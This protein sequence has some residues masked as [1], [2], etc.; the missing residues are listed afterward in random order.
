MEVK[1]TELVS[2]AY[3]G[4]RRIYTCEDCGISCEAHYNFEHITPDHVF[5][6]DE[7]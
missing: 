3:D 7:S 2:S 5:W 1:E 6:S 4:V